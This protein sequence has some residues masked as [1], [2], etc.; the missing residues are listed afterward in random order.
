M[1]KN[2]EEKKAY[3][4]GPNYVSGPILSAAGSPFPQHSL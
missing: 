1:K 3:Y 4:E 2:K